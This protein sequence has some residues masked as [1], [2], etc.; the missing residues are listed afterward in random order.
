MG[1]NPYPTLTSCE[2]CGWIIGP[3]QFAGSFLYLMSP[4]GPSKPLSA[5]S[6]PAAV[7]EANGGA[8][9]ALPKRTA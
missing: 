2:D 3:P 4:I 6:G 5:G 1:L 7:R 8:S 9:W